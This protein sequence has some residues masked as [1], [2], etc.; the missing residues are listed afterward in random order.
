MYKSAMRT[1]RLFALLD[2]LRGSSKPISAETLALAMDVSVRTIYRDMATLQ[3]MGAPVRGEAGVGYQIEKGYF[4]P[5]LHFDAD[6]RDAIMLGTRLITARGDDGLAAAARRVAAKIGAVLDDQVQ[7]Q[8]ARSPF[9]AVSRQSEERTRADQHLGP[10][11][12]AIRDRA[13]LHIH[14]IDLAGRESE[15]QCR[16]LG[17]TAFD[18][19]WLLT[20]WCE[21]RSDFRNLRVDRL[22]SVTRTGA[23]FRHERGK[24]FDDYLA[25]LT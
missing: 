4:L 20:I 15:R 21:K 9:M 22:L 19:V 23:T 6:E 14:Y 8:Y 16:P 13:V 18:T 5:P 10:L 17:L 1:L 24:R 25:T 2:Q 11:R 7:D 3:A 12:L